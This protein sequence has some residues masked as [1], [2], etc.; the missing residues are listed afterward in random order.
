MEQRASVASAL[1]RKNT[2]D[3]A[4]HFDVSWVQVEFVAGADALG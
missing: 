2:A 1:R 4:N 3:E